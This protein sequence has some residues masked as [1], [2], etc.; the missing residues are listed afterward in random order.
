M[1][2]KL[3]AAAFNKHDFSFM[4]TQE[5][6]EETLNVEGEV[7]EDE[8]DSLLW[9]FFWWV[10]MGPY[11]LGWWIQFWVPWDYV[12]YWNN[13]EGFLLLKVIFF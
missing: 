4:L 13:K 3:A 6:E 12:A 7:Q 1:L 8:G 9:L 2:G 11:R 5:S 10:I